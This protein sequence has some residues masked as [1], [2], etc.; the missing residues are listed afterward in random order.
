MRVIISGGGSGGHIYPALAIAEAL[1]KIKADIEILFVGAQG[2]MEMEK[3][4]AAGFNI[5]GLWISGLQ[6]RLTIKNLS[7][8][9]KV[10]SS[11]MKSYGI[12]K[13]FDPD[14]AVGVGGYASGPLLYAASRKN[15][16]TLIQE[17]NSY[18]GITN[19]LLAKRVDKICVA[20]ERMERYF[21]KEKITTTGNPVRGNMKIS[22]SNSEEAYRHFGLDKEKKTILS[23][24]GS[25]GARSLNEAIADSHELL[26]T[27]VD[28][29]NII[30]QVGKLYFDEFKNS[31][32]GILP[33]VKILPFIDRMDLAYNIADVVMCRAGAM[34]ITELSHLSQ[35]AILIPSPHV[36]EDHQTK[37]AVALVEKGAAILMKDDQATRAVEESIKLAFDERRL[38]R[39]SKEI[40]LMGRPDAAQQ[41]AAMVMEL[42]S[43]R[44]R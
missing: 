23:V 39:L 21:P 41:I 13:R 40:G 25:Q 30:W 33:N 9:F 7:F 29:V 26:A 24:G 42:G 5:E 8:P 44:R 3:I 32:S 37:N 10:A 15:I 27:Q 1:K 6:R 34:T 2:R 31:K 14:V 35:P 17:Q 38:A 18:P 22:D 28:K 43:K 36:A 20:Y 19:K 16:P 12:L 4:P 11:V